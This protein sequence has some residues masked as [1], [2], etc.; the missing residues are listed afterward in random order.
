MMKTATNDLASAAESTVATLNIV[1]SYDAAIKSP[2]SSR[3]HIQAPNPTVDASPATPNHVCCVIDVSGSM[4]GAAKSKDE[5]GNDAEDIGL[6]ILDIVKFSTMVISQSL[7]A[8]DKLSIVSYSDNAKVV[9]TPIHMTPEGKEKVKSVLVALKPTFRTNLFAGLKAGVNQAHEA[10]NEYVSSIF[11]LTDGVPN[12]HPP[13]SYEQDIAELLRETPVFGSIS[14]FGFGYQLDSKLLVDISTMGG[15]YYSF[16]PDAGMVGTCFINALANSRCA[17]GVRPVLKISGC[18]FETLKETGIMKS[19]KDLSDEGQMKMSLTDVT[20]DGR[21]ETSVVDNVICVKLPPLRYGSSVDIM[22]NPVLFQQNEDGISINLRFKTVGGGSTDVV[23]ENADGNAADELFHSKRVQFVKDAFF[24]SFDRYQSAS[25]S[26]NTFLSPTLEKSDPNHVDLDLLYQDMKGQATEAIGDQSSFETWG[27]HY[28]LS[29]STAHLHQFCNN[30]KDPGVQ[31][32]GNG[33]LFSSLQD[34]LDDIFE[35]VPPPTPSR[36]VAN[37]SSSSQGPVQMSQVFNNQNAVCVHGGTIVTV[38]YPYQQ[39]SSSS[40]IANINICNIK[41]GDFI[42]TANG[43]YVEVECLVE[44]VVAD[45]VLQPPFDLIKVGQLLVTPYHPVKVDQQ[46]DWQFPIDIMVN[47]LLLPNDDSHATAY[48]VY[49]LVLKMGQRHNAVIMN[50][51]EAITLAHGITNNATLQHSYFGTDKVVSDL[52]KT[53]G[54]IGG[55]VVLTESDI[56]RDTLSGCISHIS[57]MNSGVE[58]VT[59]AKITN[60]CAPCAA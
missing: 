12:I 30:F 40:R 23:V 8:H 16:I 27:K 35:K 54:W 31:I 37:Y 43:D 26:R 49:N 44:T 5:H 1:Q 29:L 59:I 14:S 10:G 36:R 48:S 3:V 13:N 21:Y 24:M 2:T 17:Y 11:I 52:E 18:D 34:T 58:E 20:L 39:N 41:K 4:C 28:L 7:N 22:L 57:G 32:Y 42:L 53:E 51:I 6:S 15:G 19:K 9:L 25:A 46:S 50:G 60:S 33:S 56:K 55:H 45:K 47:K 38:K